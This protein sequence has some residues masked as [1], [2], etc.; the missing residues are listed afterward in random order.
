[1]NLDQG[2]S[3]YQAE[4]LEECPQTD[5]SHCLT[6]VNALEIVTVVALGYFFLKTLVGCMMESRK[7]YL[8][9]KELKRNQKETRYRLK[10]SPSA[11]DTCTVESGMA[12]STSRITYATQNTSSHQAAVTPTEVMEAKGGAEPGIMPPQLTLSCVGSG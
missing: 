7:H 8:D 3:T 10:Y 11:P 1:M 4:D 5:C 12:P 6:E 2:T 9:R